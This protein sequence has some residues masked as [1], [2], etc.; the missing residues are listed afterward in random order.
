M[1]NAAER[2]EHLS[3]IDAR[4][5]ALRTQLQEANRCER[6]SGRGIM[7]E[8]SWNAGGVCFACNGER[9]SA[10][11]SK[12]GRQLF[13]KLITELYGLE[14]EAHTIREDMRAAAA[15]EP[16]PNLDDLDLDAL[17]GIL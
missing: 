4:I 10:P 14:T 8:Y 16:L 2:I 9:F 6:C 13:R 11:R 5:R 7:F 15:N 1:S 17:L 3:N 12:S